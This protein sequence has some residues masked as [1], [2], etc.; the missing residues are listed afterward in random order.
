MVCHQLYYN[1]CLKIGY[2]I[3]GKPT[4]NVGPDKSVNLG[5]SVTLQCVVIAT[6]SA[7]SVQWNKLPMVCQTE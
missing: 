7:T 3:L 4:V 5:N 6:P 1:I 2:F